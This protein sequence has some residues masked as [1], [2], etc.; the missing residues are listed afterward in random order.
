M[1]SQNIQIVKPN[2]EQVEWADCEIGVI[3]HCDLQVFKPD[4][5]FREQWGQHPDATVFNPSALDTDQWIQTAK[6]A[7]AKYA[8]LTAKHCSGFC[9]WPTEAHGYSVKNSPWKNGKGDI[10]KD[11]FESCRK[12]G[13]KPGLYYSVTC[14]AFLNVDN[15]GTVRS[16]DKEEQRRYNRIVIQQLTELWSNYG[17]LFEIWFDGGV[18]PPEEGGPDI[19]SLLKKLQPNANVYQGLPD[20]RSLVRWCGNELGEAPYPCWSTT[21]KGAFDKTMHYTEA[22][23]G[24]PFGPIWAQAESPMYTRSVFGFYGG[25][26]WKEGEDGLV[27]SAGYLVE[28]YMET[29]GRNTNLLLGMVIDNR[30]LVPDMEIKQFS[31]FG[32]YIGKAFSDSNLLG[33]NS[34]TGTELTVKINC[35]EKIK[36]IVIME[37]IEQGERILEYRITG[38]DGAVWK[39]ICDGISV[40]HKRIHFFKYEKPERI[41]VVKLSCAKSKA[42]PIIRKLAIYK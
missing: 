36:Y 21:Y 24:D 34:G 8:I 13:I 9:L 12:Y 38:W 15:P 30:G 22:G 28:R 25:W 37:D 4:Y 5:E 11:F 19:G 16:G 18:L 40:G 6:A 27:N 7:G 29:V 32:E 41:S 3:I 39:D 2:K 1:D 33:E 14:N 10:V 26:F 23:I 20:M 35:N 31:W 42:E 17:E